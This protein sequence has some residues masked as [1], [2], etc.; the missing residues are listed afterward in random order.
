[1]VRV[2]LR[3]ILRTRKGGRE[4]PVRLGQPLVVEREQPQ[5]MVRL[6]VGWVMLQHSV[7]KIM[8]ARTIARLIEP[9][10]WLRIALTPFLPQRA[11]G[12]LDGPG[13]AAGI[14]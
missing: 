9:V 1:V 3:P 5:D 7:G 12:G 11:A 2:Q 6:N 13:K 14:A 4:M 8:G 10:Q